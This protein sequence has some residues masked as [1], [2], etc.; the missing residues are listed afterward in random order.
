MRLVI[1]LLLS[2]AVLAGTAFGQQSRATAAPAAKRSVAPDVPPVVEVPEMSC[3]APLGLGVKT[4]RMF[5]DVLT[6]RDPS[7]G[8]LI[9]LPPHKGPVTLRF[10]LHNRHTYSEEQMKDKRAAFA[11]YTA[12]IGALTSDNTLISRAAVDS[13]FRSAKDLVDRI[14]GGAGPSGVKAVAPTGSEPVAITIPEEENQVSLLGEK[15]MV[16]RADG[17]AT[18]A[19]E[20]RPVAIISNVTVEYHP[21]P[22]KPQPKAPATK[23]PVR[24]APKAPGQ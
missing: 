16:E 15:L 10:D 2:S 4:N 9:S 21:P 8:I 1:A 7:A 19:S 13:E 22:P 5:C 11:H 20:G 24:S 12:V 6:G 3:P 17:T 18:Y 23:P 14:S